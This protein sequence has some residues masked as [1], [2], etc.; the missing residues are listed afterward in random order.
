MK[1]LSESDSSNAV[2]NVVFFQTTHGALFQDHRRRVDQEEIRRL[3]TLVKKQADQA[4]AI[5]REIYFLSRKGGHVVPPA[6]ATLPPL[7]PV[8]TSSCTGQTHMG[9][10]GKGAVRQLKLANVQRSQ[11]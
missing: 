7:A 9:N 11:K 10:Q 8:T 6:Q 1:G 5:R 4:E 2:F 3:Q